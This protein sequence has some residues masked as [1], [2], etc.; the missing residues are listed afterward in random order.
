[1]ALSRRRR[2]L[3]KLKN[4]RNKLKKRRETSDPSRIKTTFFTMPLEL[5]EMVYEFS[6]YP[7]GH[8]PDVTIVDGLNFLN[9]LIALPR[10]RRDELDRIRFK[11]DML[12]LHTVAELKG[13]IV[14]G[15]PETVASIARMAF[16]LD[17]TSRPY[18][19]ASSLPIA[20]LPGF[21]RVVIASQYRSCLRSRCK[22]GDVVVNNMTTKE[23]YGVIE[24]ATGRPVP[25]HS[26]ATGSVEP[27][28]SKV[29]STGYYA[30]SGTGYN[31]GMEKTLMG[32]LM[33]KTTPS[34]DWIT[35]CAAELG[36]WSR[37]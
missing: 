16:D 5:R 13:I 2:A 3:K 30:A 7:H 19:V 20:Q 37:P 36:P 25:T 12:M 4:L 18:D 22:Y 15:G 6:I 1:M 32:S 28:P 35:W 29:R 14:H 34:N 33:W 8:D 24:E 23:L 27:S 11:D 10:A 26:K 21:V 17:S 31:N 9:L